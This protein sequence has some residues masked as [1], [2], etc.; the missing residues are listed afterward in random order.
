[1][2]SSRKPLI[3]S[4]L[5]ALIGAFALAA[6]H[7]YLFFDHNPGISFFLF[8]VFLFVYLFHDWKGRLKEATG[9]A[10]FLLAVILLLSLTYG[11]F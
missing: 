6:V 2:L 9:F 3:G 5:L 7:Q 11:L 1:M 4:S 10:W 8:I